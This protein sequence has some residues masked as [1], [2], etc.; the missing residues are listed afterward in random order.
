MAPLMQPLGLTH[1]ELKIS[2]KKI[3]CINFTVKFK[4]MTLNSLKRLGLYLCKEHFIF[5]ICSNIL[6]CIAY[7]VDAF[8]P[9]MLPY[10]FIVVSNCL[11]DIL[12]E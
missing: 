8:L 2:K 12:E 9:Q 5:N 6:Q 7:T 11:S 1:F 10:R 4:S 3:V